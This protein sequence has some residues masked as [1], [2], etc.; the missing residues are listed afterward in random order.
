VVFEELERL[1][2]SGATPD[3][4][5]RITETRRREREVALREN[6][7]WLSLIESTAREGE[8]LAEAL[9]EQERLIRSLTPE[10]VRAAARRYLDRSRYL[11]VTLYP[12]SGTIP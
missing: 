5:A 10:L 1:A 11:H 6:G 9:A 4:V 12:E 2:E 7:F 8:F 3:E